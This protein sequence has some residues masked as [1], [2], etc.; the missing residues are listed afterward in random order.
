MLA[1]LR[2]CRVIVQASAGRVRH[3]VSIEKERKIDS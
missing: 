2:N 1:S 3:N